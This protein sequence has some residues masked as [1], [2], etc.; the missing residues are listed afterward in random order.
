VGVAIEPHDITVEQKDGKW[1]GALDL[2]FS[3]RAA[4]GRD[5][6]TSTTP[7]GLG[8]DQK[9]YDQLLQKGLSITKNLDLAADTVEVRILVSDR[10]SGK[11]GT[12]VLGVK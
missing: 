10:A 8:M 1:S 11:I 2:V 3:Q 12:V 4:D 5:L 9:R 7:L 6:G